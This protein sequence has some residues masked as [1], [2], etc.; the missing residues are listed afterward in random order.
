MKGVKPV[1]AGLIISSGLLLIVKNLGYVN[2]TTFNFSS[3]GAILLACV[4]GIYFLYK[5]IFKKKM[6]T[7]LL[8]I[9][10]AGLGLLVCFYI[11]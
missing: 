7:I 1:V 5:L 9:I 3:R 10:S 8:I 6:N 4:I 11:P 2:M